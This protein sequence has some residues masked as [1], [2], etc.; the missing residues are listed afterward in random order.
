MNSTYKRRH[1]VQPD[2][3]DGSHPIN[4]CPTD[5]L[6][7]I[8]EA[9]VLTHPYPF[10][11]AIQLAHICQKW[12]A[13]VLDTPTLWSEF[14]CNMDKPEKQMEEFWDWIRSRVKNI[15]TVINLARFGNYPAPLLQHCKL[16]QIPH[17]KRLL[18]H[19]TR[20]SAIE[21]IFEPSLKLPQGC[22]DQLVVKTEPPDYEDWPIE[23]LWDL[24]ELL[25]QF[26]GLR[27]LTLFNEAGIDIRSEETYPSIRSLVFKTV[28]GIY[29]PTLASSFPN[30]NTLEIYAFDPSSS[31]EPLLFGNLTRLLLIGVADGCGEWIE[32]LSCPRLGELVID[33]TVS[34]EVVYAFI[35]AHSAIRSI[36]YIG[37]SETDTLSQIAPQITQL[38]VK[39]PSKSFYEINHNQTPSFPLLKYLF[40]DDTEEWMDKTTF[41]DLV[42]ARFLPLSHPQSRLPPSIRP[43]RQLM[44]TVRTD[45][46]DM[47]F[48]WSRS[49]L[50]EEAHHYAIEA[51][52]SQR[53]MSWWQ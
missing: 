41:E 39:R 17:I 13:I 12:R 20:I 11:T 34:K 48:K 22:V 7:Y 4:R 51:A 45:K 6:Q 21:E 53:A 8:F 52:S 25:K 14:I 3:E 35:E 28:F 27:F 37:C 29:I 16:N 24:D 31:G 36:L 18:I 26:P 32:D 1:P 50:Y 33:E 10:L 2:A 40:L 47:E 46:T 49:E 30:L 23:K 43:I 42:T 19:V 38:L 15:Q 44:L 5:I 9:A